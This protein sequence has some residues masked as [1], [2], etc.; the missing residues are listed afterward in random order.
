MAEGVPDEYRALITR[1]HAGVHADGRRGP[2]AGRDPVR[3]QAGPPAAERLRA[4]PAVDARQDRR[5]R[6]VRPPG[7]QQ[8]GAGPPAAGADGPRARGP[9]VRDPAPVRHPA[10]L[11]QPGGA[12]PRPRGNAS[13]PSCRPRCSTS[14]EPSSARSPARRPET[15][16][17]LLRGGRAPAQGAPRPAPHAA[18]GQRAGQ[19]PDGARAARPVRARRGGP[20]RP[21]A[22]RADQGRGQPRGQGRRHARARRRSTTASA[23]SP[24]RAAWGSSSRRSRRCSSAGSSS[25]AS[26]SPGSGASDWRCPLDRT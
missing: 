10:R 22:R 23:A 7:D 25:S 1:V 8:A 9:R 19:D 6:R 12:Q 16:T 26:A 15:N 13:A 4:L 24:A 11:L 5:A 17:T 3:P 2:L 20:Q 18:R 21:Q 14:D